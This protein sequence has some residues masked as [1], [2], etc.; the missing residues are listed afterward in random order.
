MFLMSEPF[1]PVAI[2]RVSP[3]ATVAMFV[4]VAAPP[5]FKVVAVVLNTF[6]VVADVVMLPPFTAMFDASVTPPAAEIPCVND[7]SAVNVFA[8]ASSATV[9]VALGRVMSL[10]LLAV[11]GAVSVVVKA[12]TGFAK[13]M[14]LDDSIIESDL[15]P[16]YRFPPSICTRPDPESMF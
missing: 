10:S 8:A 12:V 3:E 6:P 7:W 1:A 9:P 2:F 11:L 4:V 16:K 13:I 5:I 14:L 15:V